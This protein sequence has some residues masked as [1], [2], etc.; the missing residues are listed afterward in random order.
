MGI[1][2]GFLR[3]AGQGAAQAGQMLLQDKLMK[4]RD[5]ANYLRDATLK[6]GLQTQDQEFRGE[7]EL[8][9]QKN[10]QG[11]QD[12]RI[13][14]DVKTAEELAGTN[15]DAAKLLAESRERIA[16]WNAKGKDTTTAQE[17]NIR[18]LMSEEGGGLDRQQAIVLTFPEATI[19]HT[20]PNGNTSVTE[21]QLDGSLKSIATIQQ[22]DQDLP[23]VV[24]E[25]DE[26]S[27]TKATKEERQAESNLFN[28]ESGND[29]DW[30]PGNEKG[31]NHKDIKESSSAKL[32]A[33]VKPGEP[34]PADHPN[35]PNR[36]TE[37]EAPGL[38]GSEAAAG[39]ESKVIK[40]EQGEQSYTFEQFAT[41]MRRQHGRGATKKAIQETWDS[42]K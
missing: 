37:T 10:L 22:N 18:Y 16:E 35:N 28:S 38:I 14:A 12:E 3:G 39:K 5:E 2:S 20:D 41:A 40:T 33:G 11:L 36:E 32:R 6:S 19:E 17:K 8:S 9:R 30:I 25:G 23:E 24:P 31:P 26:V 42:I 4:E 7:M 15:K 1:I 13:G 29:D 27:R 34:W 21:R